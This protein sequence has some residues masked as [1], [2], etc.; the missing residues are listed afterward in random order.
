[1]MPNAVALFVLGMLVAAP[2]GVSAQDRYPSKPIQMLVAYST[3]TTTDILA[4]TFAEK[5][6]P[7]LGQNVPVQDRPGAGGTIAAQAIASAAP[8]GHMILA[9]NSSHAINPSL[10]SRLPFDTLRNFAGI[11]L[12]SAFW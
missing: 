10:Y 8:D 5:L 12:V 7:R 4:R 6:S 3:G 1:M 11:A 9:V 2:A